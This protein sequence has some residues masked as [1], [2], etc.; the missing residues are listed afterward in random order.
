MTTIQGV[1]EAVLYVDDLAAA[2]HFYRELLDLPLTL[3]F[4]DASFLQTGPHSTLILFDRAKLAARQSEIPHH[5]T[6]GQ[7]HVA[8]AVPHSSLEGWRGRLRQHG[9]AIE[10]E[11]TW[12][13]GTHS[14]YF[15]DPDGNSIELID[16]RH[17]PGMWQEINPAG[18]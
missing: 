10:H 14:I 11:Q 17:Y 2:T 1:A 7:G 16:A 8:L 13:R 6:T 15:R 18:A 5:G 4:D 12:P 3:S 9:V